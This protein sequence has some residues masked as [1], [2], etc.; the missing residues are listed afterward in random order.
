[1]SG[2]ILTHTKELAFQITKE[3]ERLG[4]FL[5]NIKADIFV[6]GEPVADHIAKLKK[7]PPHI[8]VGTPGR[9]FDLIKRGALD[10]K[11]LRFFILDE[12]DK[13]LG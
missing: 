6:G 4:K 8:V 7:T 5:P 2:L 11:K 13:M 1:V 12:C 9:I 10:L 3:Y